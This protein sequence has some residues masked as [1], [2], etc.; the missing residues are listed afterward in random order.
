M[1]NYRVDD[2]DGLLEELKMAGVE[3]DPHREDYDYGRLRGSWVP[4]ETELNCG[5]RPRRIKSAR[6]TGSLIF[7][8]I[9]VSDEDVVNISV[10]VSPIKRI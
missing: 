6:R 8:R 7:L 10:I 3:I 1:V 2:L 5:K 4:V 9:R